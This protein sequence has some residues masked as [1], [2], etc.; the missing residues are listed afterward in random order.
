[1]TSDAER[2]TQAARDGARDHATGRTVLQ[3]LNSPPAVALPDGWETVHTAARTFHKHPAAGQLP[4]VYA[5]H[6]GIEL[7]VCG[8]LEPG[9]AMT[10]ALRLTEAAIICIRSRQAAT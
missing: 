5:D 1:M 10:L 8:E 9:D 2:A 3:A 6:R 7:G 4:A